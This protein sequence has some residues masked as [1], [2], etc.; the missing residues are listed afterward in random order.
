MPDEL[1]AG[2]SFQAL[3]QSQ[4]DSFRPSPTP[5]LV[6]LEA[7]QC[8]YKWT[9]YTQL[10]S[11]KGSITEYWF[12]WDNI[13]IGSQHIPG[14]VELRTRHA[15]RDGSVGRPQQFAR[16]LGAVTE[17]W[18]DMSS[19]IKAQFL[20]RVW[21][22]VGITSGQRKFNDPKHPKEQDNIF[23][24]GGAYQLVIPNLTT[25]WIKKL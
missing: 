5:L 11:P 13:D 4:Q 16:A 24:I 14:F 12:P 8:V 18:N 17:Q 3:S 23:W 10:V 19:L 2:L 25:E 15:N 6:K 1:N 21:G 7:G 22:F 20:K 9:Q